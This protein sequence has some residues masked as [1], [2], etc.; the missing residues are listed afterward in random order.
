MRVAAIVP[1]AGRGERFK[2]KVPKPFVLV[3]GE[4]MLVRTL[5]NLLASHAFE[6]VIVLTERTQ[7]NRAK[8]ILKR[9]GLSTVRVECG[10]ATRADSVRRGLFSLSGSAEW[11]LVHDAARPLVNK[12]VVFR[13]LEAAKSSGAA[14][15]VTPVTATV[16]RL[17]PARN[18]VWSTE[19]RR[20]LCLAQTPQVFR[21]DLLLSRYRALGKKALKAT[22]EA[23]LFD[24]SAVRVRVVEG[25]VKNIKVT[26]K[27]DMELVKYYIR[28][29]EAVQ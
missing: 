27:E 10:G 5:R 21:R 2:S 12:A 26:T 15:C 7:L 17:R 29:G 28:R 18:V 8:N 4:P 13:T 11:V 1:A 19:D 3:R 14:L 20:G 22:D 16:K 6:E 25:D 23:A 9:H 24:K